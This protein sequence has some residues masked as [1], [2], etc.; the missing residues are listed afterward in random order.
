VQNIIKLANAAKN[1]LENIETI[2]LQTRKTYKI[3]I[4]EDIYSIFKELRNVTYG[5]IKQ[6]AYHI[7]VLLT[8]ELD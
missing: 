8:D 2:L 1:Q 6:Q 3:Q 7:Q 4:G 5:N